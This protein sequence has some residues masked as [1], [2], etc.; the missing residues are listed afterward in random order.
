MEATL[1]DH[2]GHYRLTLVEQTDAASAQ[3]NLVLYRQV[4]GL[5]TLG[6][7]TT[8]LYG[9]T[10]VDMEAVGGYRVRGAGSD[11]ADAPG[12]LVLEFDRA[13]TRNILLR[14]GSAANRRDTMLPDG[15]YTVMQ[16]HE[17]S[18]DGFS[19][20]WRIGSSLSR[21]TGHFCATRRP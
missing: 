16:V 8:P 21:S 19:G 14:L 5:E 3:G 2:A 17:I 15:A 12:V 7:S 13:G 20:S 18:A 1:A 6:K 9:T 10:D 4:P 11:A